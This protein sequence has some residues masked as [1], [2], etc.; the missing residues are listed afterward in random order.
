MPS[1]LPFLPVLRA[2][3]VVIASGAL[4]GCAGIGFYLQAIGGQLE[5]Y[6]ARR[7]VGNV[8]DAPGTD[9]ETRRLLQLATEVRSF[10]VETLALPDNGSY[11]RYADLK[12]PY[13]VWNVFAAPALSLEPVQ[14]CFLVVGCLSYRGYFD[15]AAAQRYAARL[16]AEGHDVF[17]GGVA[18]YSTLGWFADPLLN[19]ML[20]WGD[21]RLTKTLIHELA[22][23]AVYVNDD[24]AFNEAFAS[25]VARVG[26]ARWLDEH[27]GE[28]DDARHEEVREQSFLE[29][30][31]TT[32]DSLAGIYAAQLSD[33]E[34]LA[35]KAGAFTALEAAYRDWRSNWQGYDGY[36]N[37]M[38][39]DLNN[40]KLASIST[41]HHRVAAFDAILLAA[42]GD[43]PAFYRIVADL[44]AQERQI[45]D[46]CLDDVV[47]QKFCE[48]LA[49]AVERE[50]R[51]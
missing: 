6:G 45:R 41:Y 36:D 23:Q 27:G 39:T 20:R 11:T 51:G 50:R 9:P 17:I 26:Y 21:A 29:L 12:R 30:L 4:S 1:I 24:S 42:G 31:L 7:P 8:L 5:L 38:R 16:R 37:W 25:T 40:A 19:T 35:A 2:L 28:A 13:V 22:H 32:R 44:G 15:E 49:A 10:A 43:L 3:L 34:K 14:S 48:P 18:A 47:Q 46:R 33:E